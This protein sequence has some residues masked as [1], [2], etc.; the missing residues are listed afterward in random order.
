MHVCSYEFRL[1][2]EC[3]ST[4]PLPA[5]SCRPPL[6]S[7]LA[8][9]A[10][11]QGMDVQ[12]LRTSHVGGHVY[13]GNVLVYSPRGG[14]SAHSGD[15]YGGLHAGNAAEFLDAL[16]RSQVSPVLRVGGWRRATAEPLWAPHPGTPV[17]S[18]TQFPP[19][20]TTPTAGRREGCPGGA[21]ALVARL[22]GQEQGRAAGG[23]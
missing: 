7:K 19:P 21:A 5:P 20:T 17:L 18:L 13:A 8:E 14:L 12:V 6:L 2:A 1:H 11:A 22:R 10:E 16:R 9:L 23:V 4:F 15:W 3:A